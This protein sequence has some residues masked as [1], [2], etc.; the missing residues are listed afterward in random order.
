VVVSTDTYHAT[1]SDVIL[2][3]L[4]TQLHEATTPS[5]Y[6]LQDWSAAGLYRPS[7]FRAYLIT[8]EQRQVTWIGRLSDRDW[9]EVQARLRIAVAVT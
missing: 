2:A 7:A 4:T 1:R 6:V 8:T 3:L 9:Q 5:D